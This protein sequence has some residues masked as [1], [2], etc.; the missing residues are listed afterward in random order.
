M[1]RI[2]LTTVVILAVLAVGLAFD[3]Q[4]MK[5]RVLALAVC[6]VASALD[7]RIRRRSTGLGK[8]MWS[9]VMVLAF[10]MVLRYLDVETH[11]FLLAVWVALWV[12]RVLPGGKFTGGA[13]L[14]RDLGISLF[15]YF[16]LHDPRM[17]TYALALAVWT[18]LAFYSRLETLERDG[19]DTASM[20]GGS[21][22]SISTLAKKESRVFLSFNRGPDIP[23]VFIDFLMAQLTRSGIW[24]FGDGKKLPEGEDLVEVIKRSGVSIPIISKGYAS[25]RGC[26]VELGVM[27]EC[28]RTDGQTIIP[29]FYDVDP[30]DVRH[31][32]G[33][34]EMSLKDHEMKGTDGRTIHAWGRALR[35]VGGLERFYSAD[36]NSWSSFKL[37]KQLHLD[38]L[39]L[40]GKRDI[41]ENLV[42]IQ[43]RVR[44]VMTK[45][46]VYYNDG[47][48]VGLHGG[49]VR[50]VGIYGTGGVGKTTLAKAVYKDIASLF[51]GCSYL[52]DIRERYTQSEGL[53]SLQNQLISD[54]LKRSCPKFTYEEGAHI[55]RHRFHSMRVLIILDDVNHH[56]EL[57]PFIGKLS[58]FGPRSR[59]IVTTRD[60][61]LINVPEVAERYEVEP[62][63][64]DQALFL[65]R[66][67]AS[68]VLPFQEGYDSLFDE[69]ISVTGRIPLAIEV[70]APIVCR[71]PTKLWHGI[72]KKL[73][74]LDDPV[75]GMLTA[76]FVCLNDK[77]KEMLLDI[78]CF[79]VGKDIAKPFFM[80]CACG[81]D[82]LSGIKV[83]LDMSLVQIGE[84][85]KLWMHDELRN[86]CQQFVCN[87]D[88]KSPERHS[89]LWN[90]ED[91]V[92]L[93]KERKGTKLVEALNLKFDNS[94]QDCFTCEEFE[95]LPDLRFLKLGKAR[96][97]GDSKNALSNLRWLDWQGCPETFG[98]CDLHLKELVILDL[99]WSK[100]AHDWKGWSQ[101]KMPQ[102]RI[103]NLT[104]C[105]GLL[106][107]PDLSGFEKL[108]IL[109]LEH[110]SR[111]VNIDASIAQLKC[112]VTLNLKFCAELS[113]LPK[114]LND[115]KEMRELLIDGTSIKEIPSALANM[116]KLK[117]L[118]ASNCFSLRGLP[119]SIGQLEA[120]S[121]L[122]LDSSKIV[123]LPDSIGELV[124]LKQLSLRNCRC[125]GEL[126]D[127]IG[128]LGSTLFE[129][130]VS[131][132][133]ISKLPASIRNLRSLKVLKMDSCFIR[134]FPHDIGRL[135]NLEEMHAL[136]CRS[137]EGDIPSDIGELK[138]LR[139]LVLGYTGISSLPPCIQSLCCLQTLDLLHCNRIEAL[140]ILPSSLTHLHVISRNMKVVPF[141]DNLTK[142]E[143]L[144]LGDEDFEEIKL[145]STQRMMTRVRVLSFLWPKRFSRLKVLELSHSRI[146]DL[147][148]RDEHLPQLTKLV[149][150]GANLRRI[151]QL[152]LTLLFLSVRGCL[153]LKRLP[154]VQCLK[155]LTELQLS[156]SAVREVEGLGELGALEIIDISH[157]EIRNLKGLGQLTSLISLTLSDCDHLR[158]L[159]NIS[160]LRMLK[161]L[162]I[163]RCREIKN[164]QG[165]QEIRSSLEKLHVGE[166]K[167]E[168]SPKEA[169]EVEDLQGG[170]G[171]GPLPHCPRQPEKHAQHK[172]L[173][174]GQVQVQHVVLG[175]EPSPPQRRLPEPAVVL[176]D[177]PRE[178]T[179]ELPHFL[180]LLGRWI[181]SASPPFSL[182]ASA[183]APSAPPQAEAE[184][185]EPEGQEVEV[186]EDDIVESR[187]L[188]TERKGKGKASD[189]VD[190][191][192]ID[193]RAKEFIN[194]FKQELKLER[195]NSFMRYKE[196][197]DRGSGE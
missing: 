11:G 167:D 54:L 116:K 185:E 82:P 145:P 139:T 157:C 153:S 6:A 183:S 146:T 191:Q 27:L 88:P 161:I 171:P 13:E 40:F 186:E 22:S 196:M 84:N 66:R 163:R 62:L 68:D 71:M 107:T 103:L 14:L 109:I 65:F 75:E 180:R 16:A 162:E 113:M 4:P 46:G 179:V 98:A 19:P 39:Q 74:M 110:C 63:K 38:V 164:I 165:L 182:S 188:A 61:G 92:S 184:C 99:S 9:A 37:L 100:V 104:G 26:L 148:L 45:L 2:P 122:L 8:L 197:L 190:E 126:P 42:G 72:L 18:L 25:S 17:E 12:L 44:E 15:G 48:A 20:E 57:E 5:G 168:D 86:L 111:L 125:L 81:Y 135:T 56:S 32:R 187:L 193:A 108:E 21:S 144:C 77:T 83:L 150:S 80:W 133:G 143:E 55:I 51:D 112:L 147:W 136:R 58:W 10:S 1:D 173:P 154:T 121:V 50:V 194:R 87:G 170:C 178:A 101:I 35:E 24:V 128:K 123:E 78:A 73:R 156:H 41:K 192:E 189:E 134:E 59:I 47:Q 160:N 36:N 195:L 52:E 114:E 120:L 169:V 43:D 106:M 102:L 79:F 69:I 33:S 89:R 3:D 130:D 140:P 149:V 142:L 141:I 60:Y 105:T 49:D 91:A 93:L 159:P 118:S 76:S 176:D 155:G 95:L 131:E 29:I 90:Y 138:S 177:H 175:H 34:F 28:R 137:L 94:R 115:M 85:N 132:T 70:L 124:Q 174:H 166:R 127:S 181:S 31:V 152:P 64:P 67:H 7:G 53:K 23:D 158:E 129:L 117:I 151:L 119:E 172:L 96:I 30:S 97:I